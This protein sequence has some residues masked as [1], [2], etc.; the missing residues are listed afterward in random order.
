MRSFDTK[1]HPSDFFVRC[2]AVIQYFYINPKDSYCNMTRWGSS[3]IVNI[4]ASSFY[5]A[6][7]STVKHIHISVSFAT[8][9]KLDRLL[10]V[11]AGIL[12]FKYINQKSFVII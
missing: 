2:N 1:S 3:D 10:F 6:K 5:N 8:P 7:H 11:N 4:S 9:N 12:Y